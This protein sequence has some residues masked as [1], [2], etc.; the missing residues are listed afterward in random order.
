MRFKICGIVSKQDALLA[1]A[2]GAD[3]LGFLDGLDYPSNDEVT[4]ETAAA[5]I[6]AV[7]PFV[8]TVLVTHRIELPWIVEAARTI[9]CS[10]IQLHGNFPLPAIAALRE[11]LPQVKIS[12]VAHV[13]D[14]SSVA[15]A[16]QVAA[17]ADAVHL[18]TRTATRLGGTGLVHD[19]QISARIAREVAAP[20]ILA[21]G[22]TAANVGQAIET[23]RPYAVDVNSGVDAGEGPE[24]SPDR[25][26]AF[27]DAV[28]RAQDQ[29]APAG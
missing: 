28:R 21:G 12:R 18:D 19:W 26:S 11:Q 13:V 8:S 15:L 5:I 10:T 23:V 6:A 4:R 29:P 17:A 25:L 3:A 20:V 22:L 14:D 1:V 9:R 2:H 27:A 7:P 16:A 24:K